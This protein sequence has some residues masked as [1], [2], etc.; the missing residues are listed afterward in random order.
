MPWPIVVYAISVV[1]LASVMIGLSHF[2]GQRHAER[3]T[4]EPYE[5]GIVSTGGARTRRQIQFYLVAV[6]FVVF[7]LETVFLLSWAVAAR[8]V[9][10]RGYVE[11]AVFIAVLL[12]ALAYLWRDGALDWGPATYR[13]GTER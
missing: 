5:S 13:K 11:I 3:A 4:G 1:A 9:G 12:A 10:T 2:L 7:D 6:F 8:D